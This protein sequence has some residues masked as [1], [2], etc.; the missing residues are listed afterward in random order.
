M[1]EDGCGTFIW[2]GIVV[3]VVWFAWLDDSKIRYELQYDADVTKTAKPKDC[4][5]LTAPLG[6][7]NCSY[8][9][10]VV[11]SHH[12]VSTKGEPIISY[13]EGENWYTNPFGPRKGVLVE[14]SWLRTND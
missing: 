1:D 4:D 10:L 12:S 8:E 5:F 9:K 13:D 6:K 14:I 7:K 2:L 3:A 11:I